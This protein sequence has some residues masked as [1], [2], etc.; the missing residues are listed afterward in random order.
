MHFRNTDYKNNIQEILTQIK[1]NKPSHIKI[2]FIATDD[3]NSIQTFKDELKNEFEEFIC[4]SKIQN[5][6]DA[7]QGIHHMNEEMLT[8]NNMTKY[9]QHI[10][11]ITDMYLLYK[12]DVYIPSKNTSW[13][14][15]INHMRTCKD[16]IFTLN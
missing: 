6:L 9:E 16:N 7:N 15:F 5:R 4:H 3:Y 1:K 11:A 12:S 2:L 8:Q 10:D 13:T 14:P